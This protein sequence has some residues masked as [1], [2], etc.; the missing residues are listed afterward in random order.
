MILILVFYHLQ[1][2]S[3][4][5]H[6]KV[7]GTLF[8]KISGRDISKGSTV[9]PYGM[10][11]TVNNHCFSNWKQELDQV[12]FRVLPGGCLHCRLFKQM[13]HKFSVVPVKAEKSSLRS[14]RFQSSYCAKV[15]A[16]AIKKGG[17]GRG[18]GEEERF[19]LSPPPPPSFLF[20]LSSQLSRRTYAETLATQARKKDNG[21]FPFNQNVWS[22]F[23]AISSSEWNSIFKKRGQPRYAYANFGKFFPECFKYRNLVRLVMARTQLSTQQLLLGTRFLIP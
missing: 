9:F 14:K 1:K 20:L 15:R 16:E 23:S 6:W 21:R 7:N 8:L 17:R 5:S 3:G 13:E 10:F 19:L 11:Q 12:I 18:R 22:V 2:I 4:K